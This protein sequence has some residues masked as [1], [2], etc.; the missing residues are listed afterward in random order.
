[1]V[2]IKPTQKKRWYI[3]IE[4]CDKP[5]KIYAS[6]EDEAI[7]KLKPLVVESVEVYENYDFIN[8]IKGITNLSTLIEDAK[9]KYGYKEIWKF[10][11]GAG[12]ILVKL[13]KDNDCGYYDYLE[14]QEYSGGCFIS[15]I[16]FTLGSLKEFYDDYVMEL[17]ATL[18]SEGYITPKELKKTKAKVIGNIGDYKF[19]VDNCGYFYSAHRYYYPNK[20]NKAEYKEFCQDS[21]GVLVAH[22]FDFYFPDKKE[23]KDCKWW[24][25]LDEFLKWFNEKK[26]QIPKYYITPTYKIVTT[27]KLFLPPEER[28]TVYRYPYF[29]VDRELRHCKSLLEI[30]HTWIKMCNPKCVDINWQDTL[31]EMIK[32]YI[33]WKDKQSLKGKQFDKNRK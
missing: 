28:K 20:K 11:Y 10:P 33:E 13:Y 3:K 9:T 32:K 27:A 26:K 8:Y 19:W 16:T 17:Q 31:E 15:P 21:N 22:D 7:S 29:N 6:T 4:D 12:A 18:M 24:H 1:M 14:Y 5:M 23:N 2:N 30:S 25:S